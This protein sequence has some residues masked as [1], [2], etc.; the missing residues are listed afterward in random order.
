M[1]WISENK[2][3]SH[4]I[5][6]KQI[7]MIGKSLLHVILE[8]VRKCTPPWYSLIGD[9]ATDVANREQFNLSIRWVDNNYEIHEDPLGVFWLPNT[10]A[11]TLVKDIL[12]RC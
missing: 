3:L 1:T 9:K 7:E 8:N 2:Y 6:N 4:D 11:D 10:T 5:M 12:V